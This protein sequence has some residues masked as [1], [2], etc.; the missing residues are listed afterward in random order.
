MEYYLV[1]KKVHM[2]CAVISLL[3]FLIRGYWMLTGGKLLHAKLTKI[4]PHIVD[5]LLLASA[6]Y[7]VAASQ[8]YPFV[9]NWVTAKVVLLVAYIVLG[10]I[11]LKGGKSKKTRVA[12]FMLSVATMIGIFGI[13]STKPAL[14]FF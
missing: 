1:V 4:L 8:M 7:L 11:A 5:T 9:V 10:T 2:A 14:A 6:I 13:A 3:G 12:A